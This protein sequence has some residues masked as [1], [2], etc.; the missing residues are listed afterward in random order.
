MTQ[1]SLIV[2][3]PVNNRIVRDEYTTEEEAI[4]AAIT[5]LANDLGYPSLSQLLSSEP[6]FRWL[7]LQIHDD[8][9]SY[10]ACRT[11]GIADSE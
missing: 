5:G 9:D 11:I 6:E 1:A 10:A 4:I 2:T 7:N 8:G 3:D